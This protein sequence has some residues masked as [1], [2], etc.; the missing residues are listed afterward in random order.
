MTLAEVLALVE[1]IASK[2]PAVNT[3]VENDVFRLNAVPDARY[4]VFAFTQGVHLLDVTRDLLTLQLHLF[5]VD[6]MKEDNSNQLEVQS[7][8]T[9]VLSN[10]L[11]TL[12]EYC[13]VEGVTLTPFNQRFTD[14]CAGVFATANI[15]T[16]AMPCGEHFHIDK[17]IKII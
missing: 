11:Q 5:Y 14:S 8:G 7:V 17:E 2:Q 6:R 13:G 10:V 3:I 15:S 4:G 1:H 16:P 9:A 12:A